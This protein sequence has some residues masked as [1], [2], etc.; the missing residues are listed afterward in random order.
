MALDKRLAFEKQFWNGAT[1]LLSMITAFGSI[2]LLLAGAVSWLKHGYW[3]E[4]YPICVALGERCVT[5]YSWAGLNKITTWLIGCDVYLTL[6]V[7]G[8]A[9]AYYCGVRYAAIVEHIRYNGL[10]F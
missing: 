2:G 1:L 8:A 6:I 9:A 10:D 4:T 7:I 3:L 5:N